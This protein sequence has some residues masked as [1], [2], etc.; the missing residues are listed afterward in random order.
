[1]RP[2]S[3]KPVSKSDS[4]RQFRSNGRSTKAPNVA[5]PPMRGGYRF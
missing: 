2:L 5:P 3:R 4:A 1:M